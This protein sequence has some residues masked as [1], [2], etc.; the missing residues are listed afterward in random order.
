MTDKEHTFRQLIGQRRG[1]YRSFNPVT[2]TQVWQW[3]CAMGD[4]NPLYLD[5]DYRAGTEFDT[6]V[7]PPAMMQMWT[8]RDF[9]DHF[10][11]GSLERSPYEIFTVMAAA[12]VPGNVA[13]N[14][15]I[16]FHRYL[17]EGERP[18]HYSTIVSIS[19]RKSTALGQGYFVTEKMECTTEQDEPFA[20]ALIT[21]FQYIPRPMED[22]HGADAT[23]PVAVELPDGNLQTR[24]ADLDSAALET[25][26]ALPALIV[27]VTHRLIV[28]GAIA[29]QD[30]I[31]VHHNVPAAQAAGMPDIFMNILTTCGLSARYLSDWAGPGSRLQALKFSL[32]APNH[33][34][35]T[36]VLEGQVAAISADTKAPGVT[37]NFAGRNSLGFHVKGAGTLSLTR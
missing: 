14:Y 19:D 15:D 6:L 27:P 10:A 33:P 9:N 7:A 26:Q 23:A 22:T 36:M 31:P 5:D 17:R 34:G 3:C 28:G 1:P 25:G 37:V 21:F 18:L 4:G 29:T 13:V 30:F 35:D 12:G 8:M 2:R 11:P 24:F 16:T 32:M 20:E